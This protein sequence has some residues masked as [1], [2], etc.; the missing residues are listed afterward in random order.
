VGERTAGSVAALVNCG[1]WK[2]ATPR[3]K[4]ATIAD[5]RSQVSRR[6]TGIKA[7]VLTDGEALRVF[8]DACRPSWAEGFRLY[9]IYARAV[10][11]APLER[12]IAAKK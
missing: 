10:A 12:S 7:P 3:Q 4:L 5:V 11:F 9:L 2:R 8:D 1:E 6:D